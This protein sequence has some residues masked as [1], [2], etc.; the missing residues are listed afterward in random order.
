MMEE[1]D[2]RPLK[3]KPQPRNLDPMSVGELDAYIA[4]L[5]AEIARARAEIVRKDRI[6]SGAEA[7]FKK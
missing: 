5:E 7:L 4:E 1:E 3:A 2:L 6:K